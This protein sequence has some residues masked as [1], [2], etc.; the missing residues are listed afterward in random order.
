MEEPMDD[1]N[2]EPGA[3]ETQVAPSAPT[4]NHSAETSDPPPDPLKDASSSALPADAHVDIDSDAPEGDEEEVTETEQKTLDAA[5]IARESKSNLLDKVKAYVVEG[6]EEIIGVV[7]M[8]RGYPPLDVPKS[9]ENLLRE[10]YQR[11]QEYAERLDYVKKKRSA[12]RRNEEISADTDIG[13]RP[14]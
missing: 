9:E 12:Q 1:E 14:S 5:A 6:S 4:I 8:G 11:A 3:P 13:P 7:S 2:K 10:I